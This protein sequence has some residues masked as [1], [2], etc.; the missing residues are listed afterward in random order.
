MTPGASAGLAQGVTLTST[1]TFP[2][3]AD[4]KSFSIYVVPDELFP[5]WI[6]VVGHPNPATLVV[7]DRPYRLVRRKGKKV[8]VPL[9]ACVRGTLSILLVPQLQDAVG[10]ARL[11]LPLAQEEVAD[12]WLPGERSTGYVW[13]S[14]R[15]RDAGRATGGRN[16]ESTNEESAVAVEGWSAHGLR[17]L[18]AFQMHTQ[19][20]R[21]D[22]P[23]D[24]AR[25][26]GGTDPFVVVATFALSDDLQ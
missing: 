25:P 18:D 17:G 13:A 22:G 15:W 21:R 6:K 23:C 8:R 2:G 14:R 9:K 16:R 24:P 4:P 11:L 26:Y 20:L 5:G 19:R 7:E 10:L 1:A 12:Q 3:V